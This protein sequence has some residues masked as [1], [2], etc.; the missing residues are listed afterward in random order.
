MK[1]HSARSFEQDDGRTIADMSG[2]SRQPLFLPR[3]PGRA[4]RPGGAGRMPGPGAP[5]GAP[6]PPQQ[7]GAAQPPSW[8][9][10]A[11]SREEQLWA[12]LG[13]MKAALLV[14]GVFAAGLGLV[15]LL[16][17]LSA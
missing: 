11:P 14:G 6:M 10:N 15:V 16:F 2:I 3:W 12:M 13:A 17:V 9:D 4:G 7:A 8:V 5:D 1:G